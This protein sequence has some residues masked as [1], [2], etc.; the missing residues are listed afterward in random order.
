MK[1]KKGFF[2]A[3]FAVFVALVTVL[4]FTPAV[5]AQGEEAKHY[6]AEGTIKIDG[7]FSEWDGI[8]ILI[9]E[10][11]SVTGTIYYWDA[12]ANNWSTTNPGY[13]TVTTNPDQMLDL[14][15]M[16]MVHS[17]DYLYILQR[18]AWSM[19]TVKL[20]TGQVMP[21]TQLFP[22]PADFN[23][24]YVISFD[25]NNDGKYDYYLDMNFE[26]KKGDYW[27]N[28]PL[29]PTPGLKPPFKITG[30]IYQE[31]NAGG[32]EFNGRDAEVL[33]HQFDATESE[34][35]PDST[36]ATTK[37]EIKQDRH[38]IF[39]YL[40]INWN[41]KT[42]VRYEAHSVAV[43]VT[44]PEAYT[45]DGHKPYVVTGAGPG[46]GPHVRVFN[47]NG[48]AE[49]QPNRLFAYANSYRGGVRVAA[50]DIDQD[51]TDEIITGTGENG[52]PHL[53]VFEKD[54]HVRGIEF[55][56]F[57]KSFRG[58]MDVASGDFDG[59]GKADIAVSQFSKGQAWVKVYRYNSA[60]AI[61]FESNVFGNLECGATVAMGDVDDDNRA[62]LIVGAGRCSDPYVKVFDYDPARKEGFQKP[63]FYQFKDTF[64]GGKGVDVAA[65]DVDGDGKA[66]IAISSLES[67]WVT[68]YRYDSAKTKVLD[69]ARPFKFNLGTNV[70]F[71]DLDSDGKAELIVGAG[72]GGGPQVR[73]YEMDG[74]TL[75]A[76]ERFFAYS[77]LL[78]TGVDVAGAN[79]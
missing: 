12:L 79:F 74:K 1:L 65:A 68:V 58:G 26:W 52:G 27:P 6:V 22:A 54:G 36:G 5:L 41:E 17:E 46:G 35:M 51:G 20:A 15:E 7:D 42:T 37:I 59:D 75:P 28:L 60:R 33:L 70:S 14:L 39:D 49:S 76:F 19:F 24:D 23:H 69:I 77:R 11:P 44:S 61:L 43:D 48:Q 66:E 4:A 30:Y 73:V 72:L 53:R 47:S 56:P 9:S 38:Q 78:R 16:K 32:G 21:Y 18:T 34:T 25:T 57:A 45:F 55:F 8:P 29:V 71:S 13:P 64:S 63:I 67:G 3:L 62:E 40:K 31:A 2:R 10:N 50:G